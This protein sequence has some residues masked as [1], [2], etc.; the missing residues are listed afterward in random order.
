MAESTHLLTAEAVRERYGIDVFTAEVIRNSLVQISRHMKTTL[1]KG[2]YSPA[3]R[4]Y[5]DIATAVSQITP[6]GYE[7]AAVTEGC[8][9]HAFNQQYMVNSSLA[10]YGLE[11]MRPGDVLICN[12]IFRGGIHVPDMV[13]TKIVY[14]D[15]Q[16]A[17][18][19][20]DVA[21]WADVGGATAGSYLNGWA[22]ESYQEGIRIPPMLAYA[23][24]RPVRSTVNLLVENTR[25]P[26]FAV[27][28][29]RAQYGAIKIGEELVLKLIERYG[30][31]TV[32]A[33]AQYGIDYNERLMRNAIRQV[34][35]GTYEAVDY[36]DDDGIELE[37]IRVKVA[38]TVRG[39]RMLM[40]F[41]G[42]QRQPLGNCASAWGAEAV[43]V[44][45]SSK[46]M[47]EP[48]S[49]VNAGTFKPI[50]I[51]MPAGSIVNVL[52]PSST[53]NHQEI[54]TKVIS[55]IF[56]ALSQAMPE[57]GVAPDYGT[58]N[59]F[60]LGGVDM[61][62]GREGTPW[63]HFVL[64]AGGWGGTTKTDGVPYCLWPA[65][66]CYDPVVEFSEQD[67]PVVVLTREFAIDSGG[68]G[69]HR[70]GA[71]CYATVLA[72]GEFMMA[73]G[74]DRSRFPPPGIAGGGP[75]QANFAYVMDEE[76]AFAPTWNGITPTRYMQGLYGR[77]NS[78]GVPDPRAG[79]CVDT[80]RQSNKFC[81]FPMQ[82]GTIFRNYSGGGGGWG[83]PLQ[84]DPAQVQADVRNELVSVEGAEAFYG[85]VVDPKTLAV[86]EP[87]TA[88]KRERLAAL[89]QKGKWTPPSPVYPDWP[90]AKRWKPP[91]A[92][93]PLQ[94]G[95]NGRAH[96]AGRAQPLR[97]ARAKVQAH[98]QAKRAKARTANKRRSR[99][100]R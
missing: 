62:P 1:M 82:K 66:N 56:Q 8:T 86:N 53:N 77:F 88:R 78:D 12:D 70:G 13:L 23:E 29:L 17:F 95:T 35:D 30:L 3:I 69:E 97:R 43:R 57:W 38:I 34:P 21:H 40:D 9:Q 16:P 79:Y 14:W 64:P 99:Q 85:V 27:G 20:S 49:P 92:G 15:G 44:I 26:N 93:Y 67:A 91:A 74:A 28:D 42:T 98:A 41:S 37:P 89:R 33:G 65:G 10:E 24:G 63:V 32:K 52:P 94:A 7:M 55:V 22:T 90:V 80:V 6:D 46:I 61:R 84:R 36:V 11:N 83:D 72:M 5:M 54:G 73:A 96:L 47:L 50:E 4:D 81:F 25:I 2:S 48:S 59:Q 75:G 39:D 87:A 31:Q 45:L 18:V 71:A 100:K 68:P 60:T 58:N 51:I 76:A 19:V